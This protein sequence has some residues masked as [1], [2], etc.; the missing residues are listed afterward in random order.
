MEQFEKLHIKWNFRI[1]K[2]PIYRT[3]LIFL[4]AIYLFTCAC[5]STGMY[6]GA[7]VEVR[8]QPEGV[9]SLLPSCAS[10]GLVSGH[11]AWQWGTFPPKPSLWPLKQVY[12]NSTSTVDSCHQILI[13]LPPLPPL[14][15]QIFC[16]S[17]KEAEKLSF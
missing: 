6:H 3:H 9:S 8:E 5:V 7:L 2:I 13:Q 11:K 14:L 12:F 15:L 1:T 17:P 16:L 10:W 4:H